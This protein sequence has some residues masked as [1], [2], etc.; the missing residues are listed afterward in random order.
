MTIALWWTVAPVSKF[1]IHFRFLPK[2]FSV[3]CLTSA[4]QKRGPPAR[5]SL[6]SPPA[7]RGT[8]RVSEGEEEEEEDQEEEDLG[9]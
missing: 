9:C 8:G 3:W 7:S 5:H 6:S 4:T 1:V 2:L